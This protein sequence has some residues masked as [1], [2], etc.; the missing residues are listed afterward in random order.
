M[1]DQILTGVT[2]GVAILTLNRPKALNSLTHEMVVAMAQA[3]A[4][5]EADDGV[6]A[7]VLAGAGARGLCAGGDVVAI[8]DSA[9]AGGAAAREFWRDEYRLNAQIAAFPK[10]YVA[11]M[12]GFVM[13]G[14]I[15]VSAHA[16]T[17]IVTDTSQLAMPEV[18]IGFVPD[19]GG[20][21]LLARAQGEIGLHAALTGASFFG[22]DA[23]ALGF[24][25]HYVPHDRLSAFVQTIVERDV[26]AALA[27]HAVAPPASEL[28]AQQHWIDECYSLR[29]V[30]DIVSA[31]LS[32]A[33]T[34]ANAAAELIMT[35]SPLA[36][37]VALAAVRR[38]RELPTLEDALALEYRV[39]SAALRS[40]DLV[41]GVRAQLIDKDRNPKWSP[42][43]LAEVATADVEAFFQPV[44]D[45]LDFRKEQL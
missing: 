11:L 15:G 39:S 28:L 29:T 38:A 24:A 32:H 27:A 14:G 2:G 16:N 22:A 36:L 7:V 41:E 34:R 20:T 1:T 43:T 21:R 12:D 17:R 9:K 30:T 18:G 6:R 4:Q 8:H 31:L 35:R 33:D 26:A 10:P 42:E 5:W 44:A 25:D 3:L 45:E 23:I 37:S 40:H 13:G 19:V